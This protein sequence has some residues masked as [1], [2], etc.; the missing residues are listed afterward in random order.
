[1]STVLAFIGVSI[2][3]KDGDP[4]DPER[5]RRKGRLHATVAMATQ[6]SAGQQDAIASLRS[7]LE[8]SA[9]SVPDDEVLATLLEVEGWD[10]GRAARLVEEDNTAERRRSGADDESIARSFALDPRIRGSMDVDQPLLDSSSGP[11]TSGHGA[12]SGLRGGAGLRPYARAGESG[13]TSVAQMIWAA[14]TLPFSLASSLLLFLARILRIRA[15]FPSLFGGGA[16]SRGLGRSDPR[17]SAEQFVREL[18]E[19]T[20]STASR[21]TAVPADD[22]DRIGS[23]SRAPPPTRLPPFFIGSYAD[24]LRTAKEQIKILVVV[25]V[26]REHGDV[27]RF[28]QDTLTDNELVDLLSK[29]D[30]IVWGGDVREREAYQVATT[31]QASTYP[32]VAF[33]A[34]QP[35]RPASRTSGAL[36]SSSSPRAA[37]LS[38]LEGSPS[39]ATSAASIASHI[40]DILLPRTRNYLERLRADKRRRE[41]ERQLRAEQDRAYQEA[42]RRDA[43]RITQKREEE[44]QKVLEAQRIREE[45]EQKEALQRKQHAWQMWAFHNLVPQ[46]PTGST[47]SVRLSFRLPS[48]KTLVRQFSPTDTVEAVF[49]FVE[50]ASVSAEAENNAFQAQKPTDYQHTYRFT[51]VTGYPRKRIEFSSVAMA[52]LQDVDGL[53]KGASLII[54]GQVLGDKIAVTDDEDDDDDDGDGA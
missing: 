48:G 33:I 45:R 51:L 22:T 23:G 43:E 17:I 38:R 32:F 20:G 15:L 49:A 1:M 14:L 36:S 6:R 31:L 41:V 50:S 9:S 25:L 30:F 40:S 4:D 21:S 42:S 12:P 2:Y 7:I 18:E 13:T 26:S 52:K 37:V 28:K 5:Q 19:Q 53:S 24:A 47:A 35:P 16:T 27:D 3:Q 10:I 8:S 46:E 54:E 44:R 29:D 39:S 11:F 34:L